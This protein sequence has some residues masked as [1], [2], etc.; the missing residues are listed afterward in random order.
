[1]TKEEHFPL[2]LICS[3]YVKC[4]LNLN[5]MA[6]KKVSKVMSSDNK[7]AADPT[8]LYIHIRVYG[9]IRLIEAKVSYTSLNQ[10]LS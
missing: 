9:A 4:L 6:A 10:K 5:W 2:F 7:Q 1:M 3:L 8:M